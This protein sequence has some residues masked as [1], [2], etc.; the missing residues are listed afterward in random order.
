MIYTCENKGCHFLFQG[1]EGAKAC[2]DCGKKRIRPAT[3]AER[4][5]LFRRLS[6]TLPAHKRP[7]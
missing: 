6:E 4:A 5:E 7:G 3:S 2:P 1:A